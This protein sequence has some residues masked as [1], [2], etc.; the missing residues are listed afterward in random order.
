M[1]HDSQAKFNQQLNV[2]DEML[3]E[4]DEEINQLKRIIRIRRRQKQKEK[5]FAHAS[6]IISPETTDGKYHDTRIHLYFFGFKF[7]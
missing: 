3:E 6:N 7:T 5:H 4:S 1:N 2:V